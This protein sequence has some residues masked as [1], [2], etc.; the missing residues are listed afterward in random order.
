MES[1]ADRKP[2]TDGRLDE[3]ALSIRAEALAIAADGQHVAVVQEPVE[4]RGGDYRVGEHNAPFGNA[5]FEVIGM[6]PVS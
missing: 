4:D 6:A 3:A 2:I 5:V 1:G